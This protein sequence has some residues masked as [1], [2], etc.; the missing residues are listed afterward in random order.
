MR[1]VAA[2][3]L[4]KKEQSVANSGTSNYTGTLKTVIKIQRPEKKGTGRMIYKASST[5]SGT[6]TGA[7]ALEDGHPNISSPPPKEV[8]FQ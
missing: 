1:E 2:L 5:S 8:S 6:E 4:R 3:T 7:T